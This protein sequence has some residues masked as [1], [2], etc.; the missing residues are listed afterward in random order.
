[1]VDLPGMLQS[2]HSLGKLCV[3]LSS[4]ELGSPTGFQVDQGTI[5]LAKTHR[6]IIFPARALFLL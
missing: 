3:P 5:S 4:V 6:S 2:R 1:M